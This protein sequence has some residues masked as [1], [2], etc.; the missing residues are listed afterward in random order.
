MGRRPRTQKI[1]GKGNMLNP[2]SSNTKVGGEDVQPDT[3]CPSVERAGL[4]PEKKN[5]SLER[6]GLLPKVQATRKIK[7]HIANATNRRSGRLQNLVMP[8][9]NQDIE[10][11]IDE[12]ILTE[13]DKEDEP[14]THEEDKQPQS[15]SKEKNLEDKIVYLIDLIKE[16]QK[17]AEKLIAM[18]TKNSFCGS[19]PCAADVKYKSL[20]IDSQKKIEV[21]EYENHQLAM[22]LE[23]AR[24]KI[25]AIEALENENHQ[26][27]LKLEHAR[28]KVEAVPEMM[29]KLKDL[30]LISNLAKATAAVNVSS[31]AVRNVLARGNKAHTSPAKRTRLEKK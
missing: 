31:K 6:T 14:P 23:H 9:I 1:E 7:K 25:E 27:A 22:K 3:T 29:E 8:A 20:Y 18:A 26:L 19:I 15:T 24:A 16:Q 30:I 11:V 13:S 21:L 5:T 12:I 28:G 17:M 2:Q 4:Q 10:R